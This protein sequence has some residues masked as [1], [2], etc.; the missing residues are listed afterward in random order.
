MYHLR[1][2]GDKDFTAQKGPITWNFKSFSPNGCR[3][4]AA[5]TKIWLDT[6]FQAL[7]IKTARWWVAQNI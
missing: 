1:P 7:N 6:W 2:L 5:T 3:L 4:G